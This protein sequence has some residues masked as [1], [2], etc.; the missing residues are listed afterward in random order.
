V[1][2][3]FCL[4]GRKQTEDCLC[5]PLFLPRLPLSVCACV[6]PSLANRCRRLGATSS[7]EEKGESE[8][9]K[10]REREAKSNK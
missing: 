3:F 1:C 5:V 8:R 4:P 6:S 10:E 2:L 7:G 9:E